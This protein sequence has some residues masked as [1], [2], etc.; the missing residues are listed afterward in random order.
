MFTI[1]SARVLHERLLHTVLHSPMSFFETT[2][3]GRIIN[4]FSKDI[5]NLDWQVAVAF[6]S[7]F[8][9]LLICIGS[10]AMILIVTPWFIIALVPLFYVYYRV[11]KYYRASSREIKRLDAI[12]RSPLFAHFGE[13]LTG[14]SAPFFFFPFL[15]YLSLF[16]SFFFFFFSFF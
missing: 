6:Q 15:L 14:L 1:K 13:T 16:L 2:P 9:I 4:R 7:L 8:S 10:F 5:D 11:Q 12:S 3:I